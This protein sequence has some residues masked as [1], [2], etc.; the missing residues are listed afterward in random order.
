MSWVLAPEPAPWLSQLPALLGAA[1]NVHVLAPWALPQVGWLPAPLRRPWSRRALSVPEGYRLWGVPGWVAVETGVRLKARSA[2][3]TF[4]IRFA[5]RRAV[6]RAAAALPSM[7][8]LVVAPSLAARE[9]FAR[10]RRCG[11]RCVLVEDLPSLRELHEDL[12]A[13]AAV[14]P[15][16][17]FLRNHRA[18]AS[19]VARQEAER[20]LADEIWVRSALARSRLV[21]KGYPATQIHLL[22]P[23]AVAAPAQL[24]ASSARVALLAG[25]A[26]AR[27]GL[28]EALAALEMLPDWTL[29]VRPVDQTPPEALRH[30]RVQQY[31]ARGALDG[32]SVVL[33]PAWCESHAEELVQAWARGVPIVATDR[34]AGALPVPWVQ[35]GDVTGLVE[36]L[37]AVTLNRAGAR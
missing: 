1:K 10:A 27:S 15:D 13:A 2:A 32:V 11:A 29:R 8:G 25:P 23:A 33:A 30:P 20:V 3:Q 21:D 36:A 24:P 22:A 4:A 17:P 12:D 18:G 7:T 16:E 28:R 5:L 19:D 37:R 9:V 14:H 35:R 26:L 34:A 31:G 6:G